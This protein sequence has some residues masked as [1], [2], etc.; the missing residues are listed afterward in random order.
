[1]RWPAFTTRDDVA[2]CAA[3]SEDGRRTD[4]LRST[5]RQLHEHGLFV[6]PN[7]WDIGSAKLLAHLGFQALATTS[8][9]H[10]ASLGKYDQQVTRDEMVEHVTVMTKAVDVPFNVDSE[11]LFADTPEG[12]AATV[13]LLAGA[14][15]AGCSIEDY[16]PSTRSID[17]IDVATERVRAAAE[18]AHRHG[19]TLT[20]RAE[21]ALYRANDLADTIRRLCAYRDAGADVLYAPGLSNIDD[22]A[23]V[24]REVDAPINVLALPKG[25]PTAALAEAGVRR[26]S[27][28]GA[29]AWAAYGALVRGAR[30]LI[31][32]GTSSYALDGLAAADRKAFERS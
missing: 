21:N 29:L 4:E 28:G 9:G 26:V 30:E 19:I 31:D 6:M 12:V 27:T 3:A 15:A 11:R 8:S 5:F 18:A 14:G 13:D 2:M 17:S 7:P 1:L 25:P 16:D 10:A 32:S 22:I 20:A 24:T 23:R